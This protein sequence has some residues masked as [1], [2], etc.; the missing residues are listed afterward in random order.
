M[1]KETAKRFSK[2]RAARL[3]SLDDRGTPLSEGLGQPQAL[4]GFPTPL[5]AL[6][7]YEEPSCWSISPSHLGRASYSKSLKIATNR[8]ATPR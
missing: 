1:K 5:D 4:G 3:S 8:L 2:G 6:K 7:G